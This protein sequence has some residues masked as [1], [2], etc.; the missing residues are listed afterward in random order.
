[1]AEQQTVPA[2]AST[3]PAAPV[4]SSYIDKAYQNLTN[5][6][7]KEAMPDYQTFVGK[8]AS[9]SNYAGKA[10]ANLQNAYG[11]ESLPEFKDFTQ[12]LYT[13]DV[14]GF[15]GIS[16][17]K[18]ANA[19]FSYATQR[20]A[21]GTR[22]TNN[23]LN[24]PS[25][26]GNSLFPIVN[27]LQNN[28][29]KTENTEAVS[30][31]LDNISKGLLS[32]L[33]TGD[34]KTIANLN[35][36]L[37]PYIDKYKQYIA[38]NK[39]SIDIAQKSLKDKDIAS[40][41]TLNT[42]KEYHN[43]LG[44]FVPDDKLK[45]EGDS[46][47]TMSP[48]EITKDITAKMDKINQL[49]ATMDEDPKNTIVTPFGG[50]IPSQLGTESE[51]KSKRDE[52]DKVTEDLTK[53]ATLK[54]SETNNIPTQIS[55]LPV[56]KQM[57]ALDKL[58]NDPKE[59]DKLIFDQSNN[60]AN[61]L[62]PVMKEATNVLINQYQKAKETTPAADAGFQ[63]KSGA[64]LEKRPSEQ[65][66][67]D[68]A[69]MT[70]PMQS[71]Q[72]A[73]ISNNLL[74][75]GD[76]KVSYF[77]EMMSKTQL[78]INQ[79][80]I[81]KDIATDKLAKD[82]TDKSVKQ[83]V[84]LKQANIEQLQELAKKQ[85]KLWDT[86]WEKYNSLSA[87]TTERNNQEAMDIQSE[88]HPF[89]TQVTNTAKAYA[90]EVPNIATSVAQLAVMTRNHF[91][92][93]MTD[94]EKAASLIYVGDEGNQIVK[95]Y[96]RV[97]TNNDKVFDYD[98]KEGKVNVRWQ[99]IAPS[100][101]KM[102]IIGNVMG[103]PGAML[104]RAAELN[105]ARP[106]T[107]MVG[108]RFG[109]FLGTVLPNVGRGVE[110]EI[111]KGANYNDA[112]NISYLRQSAQGALF[113]IPATQVGYA[114]RNLLKDA[115]VEVAEAASQDEVGQLFKQEFVKEEYKRLT[116]QTISN[117][118]LRKV[119]AGGKIA[120]EQA[121]IM[122]VANIFDRTIDNY[123][124]IQKHNANYNGDPL[125]L[126]SLKTKD[127]WWDQFATFANMFA[128]SLH[129]AHEGARE[130]IHQEDANFHYTM[131]SNT[132]IYL[133]KL[134]DDFIHDVINKD[135]YDK[136]YRALI[137]AKESFKA[138]RSD[139]LALPN[140]E[141]RVDYYNQQYNKSIIEDKIS[142]LDERTTI[143]SFDEYD[144]LNKQ[145][146][147]FNK[148]IE[149][150]QPLIK[151]NLLKSPKFHASVRLYEN[152]RIYNK[153]FFDGLKTHEDIDK[154]RTDFVEK[155]DLLK[156]EL[157][158]D[159]KDKDLIKHYDRQ[160]KTIMDRLDEKSHDLLYEHF[161]KEHKEMGDEE[162]SRT[163]ENSK[164]DDNELI[165][166]RLQRTTKDVQN[167][168]A[169]NEIL[170]R[171][172]NHLSSLS[173]ED[174]EKEHRNNIGS[175]EDDNLKFHKTFLINQEKATRE[176]E[177]E[178]AP[179][180]TTT[181]PETEQTAPTS[182]KQERAA[183]HEA[184]LMSHVG[185]L[186]TVQD[187][188]S[189]INRKKD[190]EGNYV[191]EKAPL[192]QHILDIWH[193]NEAEGV[194]GEKTLAQSDSH[195]VPIRESYLDSGELSEI[196]NRVRKAAQDK[197]KSIETF[198]AVD[199]HS[200]PQAFYK[201]QEVFVGVNKYPSKVIGKVEGG[202]EVEDHNGKYTVWNFNNIHNDAFQ[203]EE[204]KDQ[205]VKQVTPDIV[206]VTI[207]EPINDIEFQEIDEWNKKFTSTEPLR[208]TGKDDDKST[209]QDPSRITW[210]NTITG[211][212]DRG[213]TDQYRIK[214]VP[215]SIAHKE[216]FSKQKQGE[217]ENALKIHG[218][219]EANPG[220]IV[221]VIV[222][223][224]GKEVK[225]GQDGK[226]NKD[227]ML[228]IGSVPNKGD[229]KADFDK[230][231][232][233]HGI[234]REQ[235]AQQIIRKISQLEGFRNLD[236]TKRNPNGA[237]FSIDY[238]SNGAIEM[239]FNN[240]KM[241]SEAVKVPFSISVATGSYIGSQRV[242][243]G[244]IYIK[245]EEHNNWYLTQAPKLTK[246]QVDLIIHLFRGDKET[247]DFE[248]LELYNNFF[249]RKDYIT[250]LIDNGS[251]KPLHF[252]NDKVV[253]Y[254]NDRGTPEILNINSVKEF[255]KEYQKDRNPIVLDGQAAK[256]RLKEIL[257]S[258]K[259]N[260]KQDWT[261]GEISVLSLKDGKVEVEKTKAEDYIK[262]TFQT[263]YQKPKEGAP[264][265]LNAYVVFGDRVDKGPI[266]TKPK[267]K[268]KKEAI[269]S[270]EEKAP[271][272]TKQDGGSEVT[273]A[274]PVREKT[275]RGKKGND[276]DPELLKRVKSLSSSTYRPIEPAERD[277]FKTTFGEDYTNR[278]LSTLYN[279]A[280]SD[281][282]GTW[283]HAGI[284]L[285]QGAESGTL[286]HES[287]HEFSQ[288]YLTK[289]EKIKMYEEARKQVKGLKDASYLEIEEY[290]AE[291]FR[292]YML[293]GGKEYLDGRKVRNSVFDSMIKFIK[294][295]LGATGLIN[296]EPTIDDIYAKL[297]KG[298][299]NKDA[300]NT[301]NA[302]FGKLNRNIELSLDGKPYS[303]NNQESQELM[304]SM[305]GDIAS[306][307]EKNGYTLGNLFDKTKQKQVLTHSYKMLEDLYTD[308]YN[309][310]PEDS[311][312]IEKYDAVLDNFNEV[313]RQHTLR[314]KLLKD[315][316]L[317]FSLEEKE[318]E[319]EIEGQKSKDAETTSKNEQFDKQG[320]EQSS[321]SVANKE[322]LFLVSTLPRYENGKP[323]INGWGRSELVDMSSTWNVLSKH[324]ESIT[325]YS[326][327]MAKIASL[328]SKY[329]E[330]IHLTGDG[331][332][333]N[334]RLVSPTAQ[335]VTP[336]QMSLRNKVLQ[337]LSKPRIRA[338]EAVT[339]LSKDGTFT[340]RILPASR[341]SSKLVGDDFY[342]RFQLL[343]TPYVSQS[344]AGN[345]LKTKELLT[346][347]T[348]P[349]I[350][351]KGSGKVREEF[352]SNLG[353]VYSD[354]TK[355]SEAYKKLIL[356]VPEGKD[357]VEEIWKG[358][359]RHEVLQTPIT[360][361]I[362]DLS[363]Q[364]RNANGKI[365]F[366]G[367]SNNVKAL[368]NIEADNNER[369]EDF[370]VLG[371]NGNRLHE[372]QNHNELTFV[373]SELN[374]TFKYPDYKALLANDELQR[375][376][377]AKNPLIKASRWLNS[378]FNLDV[379]AEDPLFGQ[380][381]LDKDG[382]P[383]R[384]DLLNYVGLKES[385]ETGTASNGLA[386]TDLYV[387]DKLI[388][389]I[390]SLLS[391][392]ISENLRHGDKSSAFATKL[393]NYWSITN[394][395]INKTTRRPLPVD[396]RDFKD[397]S[398][399][400]EAK[401][402]F[403]GHFKAELTRIQEARGQYKDLVKNLK[404]YNKNAEEFSMFDEIL[405]KTFKEASRRLTDPEF[406]LST[407]DKDTK[408]KDALTKELEKYFYGKN[409]Q[410]DKLTSRIREMRIR[411]EEIFGKDLKDKGYKSEELLR[412]YV[413]ND[414]LMKQE[415]IIS[416]YGDT[417]F[418]KANNFFKRASKASA[419][420]T[421]AFYDKQLNTHLT[422]HPNYRLSA[423]F[424]NEN[425]AKINIK[426]EDGKIN[427]VIFKD[428][429]MKSKYLDIYEKALKEANV[430]DKLIE[431]IL[432]PYRKMTEADGQGWITLD[433][434][435][436]FKIRQGNWYGEHELAYAKA[437]KGERLSQDEMFY[438]MPIKPQYSG[439]TRSQNAALNRY[440]VP[441]FDKFSLMPLIPS[442]IK[443]TY[444]EDIHQKMLEN[445]VGYALFES[446][447]KASGYL[448][449]DGQFN[450]F[451]GNYEER[452]SATDKDWT[453]NVK[454]YANLKEQVNIEPKL[455]KE[456]I[457]TTQLRKLLFYNMFNDGKPM[458]AHVSRLSTEYNGNIEKLTNI[459]KNRLV[460]ELDIKT[461]TNAN[462]ETEYHLDNY[463]KLT[464][465]LKKEFEG[466]GLPDKTIDFLDTVKVP[467]L[468]E[469]GDQVEKD[470]KPVTV[471]KLKYSLDASLSRQ[472]IESVL[473]AI[474]SNRL[475]RQKSTGEAFIQ[476]ASTGFES[477]FNKRDSADAL[478]KYGSND[479]P[480]Y[481]PNEKTGK[482]DA[483]KVKVGL[484]GNFKYLLHLKHNDGKTIETLDRLNDMIKDDRWLDRDKNRK[485]ITMTGVRIP[486]Q[487][488]NSIEFMEVHHFMPEEVGNA[489][490]LPS[491]LVAKS[492]GDYDI[493]KLSVMMPNLRPVYDK[494]KMLDDFLSQY[495]GLYTKDDL[496]FILD[497]E[498]FEDFN[499]LTDQEQEV[500]DAYK[501]F[502]DDND[503]KHISGAE[504]I[505]GDSKKGIQNRNNEIIREVVERKENFPAL[506]T[507]NST[508]ILKDEIYESITDKLAKEAEKRG[509]DPSIYRESKY[510]QS[511]IRSYDES[512]RQF[513]ANL[514][515]KAT[516]GIAAVNNTFNQ[517]F[518]QIG[519]TLNSTFDS[520]FPNVKIWLPHNTTVE[521]KPMLGG[522]YSQTDS[523]GV[524]NLISE[525]IS[526]SMNGYVDV[527]NGPWIFYINMAKDMASTAFYL[528]NLGVPPDT[529]FAYINQPVIRE[530]MQ[531][532]GR[533]SFM[534]GKS[535]DPMQ[536]SGEFF[537]ANVRRELFAKLLEGNEDNNRFFRT[538][539]AGNRVI[540]KS[541]DLG[542]ALN[543]HAE[544][545]GLDESAFK[546]EYLFDKV[547]KLT[548][549]LNK[550]GKLAQ[551][552][553][554]Q[555][556]LEMQDQAGAMVNMQS[557]YNFD[558]NKDE[559]ILATQMKVEDMQDVI[560]KGLFPK[561]QVKALG[562]KTVLK[563]FKN[564]K[565]ILGAYKDLFEVTNH[566][567]VNRFIIKQLKDMD[568]TTRNKDGDRI[569]RL[570]KNDF[571]EYVFQNYV[572]LGA[573]GLTAYEYQKNNGWFY[574]PNAIGNKIQSFVNGH[575]EIKDY[576]LVNVLKRDASKRSSD[577]EPGLINVG[578]KLNKLDTDDV[579][580]LHENFK[581]LMNYDKADPKTNLEVQKFFRD[582]S[583]FGFL[584]SGLNYSKISFSQIIPDAIYAQRM[585]DPLKQVK[586]QLDRNPDII[587]KDFYNGFMHNN[588]TI[589]K[590]MD[591]NKEPY[592]FKDYVTY[593]RNRSFEFPQ[594]EDDLTTPTEADPNLPSNPENDQPETSTK[595]VE[596]INI[597]TRSN[598]KLGRALTN[599]LTGSAK[600]GIKYYDVETEYKRQQS[601]KSAPKL[602]PDAALKYDMELMYKLQREKFKQNP[603]LIDQINERGGLD[604]IKSSSHNVG[605]KGSRWEGKG[606]ES[607]FIKVLARAYETTAKE[608][609][610]F[611][612]SEST[613]LISERKTRNDRQVID[614]AKANSDLAD[615]REQLV[616]KYPDKQTHI[617][618]LVTLQDYKNALSLYAV[619]SV[620]QYSKFIEE[621]LKTCV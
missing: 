404:F 402:V 240:P 312:L 349:S 105:G 19:A 514:V 357:Y 270:T 12:K 273:K 87:Y 583:I 47:A 22:E 54:A 435:R 267:V 109:L 572:K 215:A 469:N 3:T 556:F 612:S 456:I 137:D 609:G 478:A 57:E 483:M 491:E 155:M 16:D 8:L 424:A 379:P 265:R 375:F 309:A 285:L 445:N 497:N 546:H 201:G 296:N 398:L 431:N 230:Y 96:F 218:K 194:T 395:E 505:T 365:D 172:R 470:G 320:N 605:V 328:T 193:G 336:A 413:V 46:Y 151:A 65:A 459:E 480:T 300:F 103:A 585:T 564:Q 17:E 239:D 372:I 220:E 126:S 381:R 156:D 106:L 548:S 408:I 400:A 223:K 152:D 222:D 444:M 554:L 529:L 595:P 52:L 489:I 44:E 89:F 125:T 181:T 430:N 144:K 504:Y 264:E 536:Y 426:T 166:E 559:S 552:V 112:V 354:D 385:N 2:P 423:K 581:E 268:V 153:E 481:K 203:T 513:E 51:S 165:G 228:A 530:L 234:S 355:N 557:A 507:P 210:R 462:G 298:D 346:K 133:N 490:I 596:G 128:G 457:Y 261:T 185:T 495:D 38:D 458:D 397:K 286:Y 322:T 350:K 26:Q 33:V 288:L 524:S 510:S 289:D 276:I 113:S 465:L 313:A 304:N 455:K 521:G 334:G 39:E 229:I 245:P 597:Y 472:K 116:G 280:N 131:A 565:F 562:D 369:Y 25:N 290:L 189:Y 403:W 28:T 248:H 331:K 499:V 352:L 468:D 111:R 509:E 579:N 364:I 6:Y 317:D 253:Y 158:T 436:I 208:T 519:L 498:D 410:I 277:W 214:I 538:D 29:N 394:P 545:T 584:Q 523:K 316:K 338:M 537:T 70:L 31:D 197:I 266:E 284:K 621:V 216:S 108:E 496:K 160:Y 262:D 370:S 591:G 59:L 30:G 159:E 476:V 582:L 163:Y 593:P 45:S 183:A 393:S 192:E 616:Q 315:L 257:L 85:Q 263:F 50:A 319:K 139:L 243:P 124:M 40:N 297:R 371:P 180:S 68:I 138:H 49:K 603:E 247:K 541:A 487:G 293:S 95:K 291:D 451:Y 115:G 164:S 512:L 324:L 27:P 260:Y 588:P 614:E 238:V 348:L 533:K 474:A 48:D 221:A 279:I 527:A 219:W 321:K 473:M 60:L 98:K 56:P 306:I 145:L 570:F 157:G 409:G 236:F 518:K 176:K 281:A 461:S 615:I 587:M 617:E 600:D 73:G 553:I 114:M 502:M 198:V 251:D 150:Y 256:D 42:L 177:K 71:L 82:P 484:V 147:K 4:P 558:T 344:D 62:N 466:R 250:H 130:M 358:L 443:G 136:S 471:E 383:V 271:D 212:R 580:T 242:M 608:L 339:T 196:G 449:P 604:F 420:G 24:D 362:E 506:I 463:K 232:E 391:D 100:I 326:Q 209:N 127:F 63:F 92:D 86:L 396:I 415:Q 550:E 93:N 392:A 118:Y 169:K 432:A 235:A 387:A 170:D 503:N 407:I 607:N 81:D 374:N 525:V 69:N 217:I 590:I 211:I 373:T 20:L 78:D 329:P 206:Q 543:K 592:R 448:N 482:T 7:G 129:V 204:E 191:D 13:P 345:L 255:D 254:R 224:D 606:M 122:N 34:S 539:V 390:N 318:E 540:K 58:I 359:A 233:I 467:Q 76:R 35:N 272:L 327:F 226:P 589:Y 493:D 526:Q 121:V 168:S 567:E 578:L 399:S 231:A 485:M 464:E 259:H 88:K 53:L 356:N 366:A 97:P 36:K 577:E 102:M 492:G 434:Y 477:K 186:N 551:A 15:T 292:K 337:D 576:K 294:K 571:I 389:D 568:P 433:E 143:P 532:V 515:G 330:F 287:F 295:F 202:L 323:V 569:I 283:T 308:V 388:M 32:N 107:K 162:L 43:T 275:I 343:N 148:R 414:F 386:T 361:P 119:I 560:N 486:V 406:D 555:N 384:V 475:I 305:D 442:V 517:L 149:E 450:Q 602:G 574:G 252:G 363:N 178:P 367:E 418:F 249:N 80:V 274:K 171:Y 303:L 419:T 187:L 117:E 447:S 91:Q 10:Y 613:P 520:K 594:E 325:D 18:Q 440:Y 360:N 179:S 310:L 311:H 441:G 37:G 341:D 61:P 522:T 244:R 142:K 302:F 611:V 161:D 563:G 1:M 269:P 382:N 146:D 154:A 377:I 411:P 347:F 620:S 278:R 188:E 190:A 23:I 561:D 429:D 110:E 454:N 307:F 353:F 439:E 75:F 195:G 182:S 368:L 140:Q 227:G 619:D 21:N 573:Q 79:A 184:R 566:P 535:I 531:G 173:D 460:K 132:D 123:Y 241:I 314:S 90:G 84:A 199:S 599:P 66:K 83:E 412:A 586:D 549:Q 175:N 378:M 401:A 547:G 446:G 534:M 438:F 167:S 501:A 575:P 55:N 101:A 11:K 5:A 601:R 299:F 77:K 618:R 246:D 437:A 405:S 14:K 67:T 120:T 99:G 174:L 332:E 488:M 64:T 340:V 422:E 544:E 479:L 610:K 416:L 301:D 335:V 500:A 452:T 41:L 516:L 425:G 213:E 94:A 417:S 494:K 9:D 342:N 421:F 351:S 207:I 528:N 542:V 258:Q 134:H 237:L 453:I 135:Q 333:I 376:N 282:W 205:S 508:F 141:S 511:A 428:N 74:P 104:G 598:D 72:A 225:F 200:N 427:S 380:R